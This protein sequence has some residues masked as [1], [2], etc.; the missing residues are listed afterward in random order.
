M[1]IHLLSFSV[2]QR[3]LYNILMTEDAQQILLTP[4]P[5]KYK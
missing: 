4:D 2:L 5:L 1:I 3:E